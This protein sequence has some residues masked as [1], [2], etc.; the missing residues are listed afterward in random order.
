[1]LLN[2]QEFNLVLQLSLIL[3]S[4]RNISAISLDQLFYFLEIQ[5]IPKLEETHL[6]SSV[7]S[8]EEMEVL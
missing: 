6:Y 4:F 5:Q 1:M 3:Q 2:I 7:L 8:S